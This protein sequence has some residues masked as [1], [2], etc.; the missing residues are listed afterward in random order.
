MFIWYC[1]FGIVFDI[2]FDMDYLIIDVF[3]QYLIDSSLMGCVTKFREVRQ[4]CSAV[5][6]ANRLF[7]RKKSAFMLK[8]AIINGDITCLDIGDLKGGKDDLFM[9][10]Y[11]LNLIYDMGTCYDFSYYLYRRK[12]CEYRQDKL[13]PFRLLRLRDYRSIKKMIDGSIMLSMALDHA[14]HSYSI[15]KMRAIADYY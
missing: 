4:E 7:Q 9:Y 2:V 3:A 10:K 15:N 5:I 6:D 1:L 8:K 14:E 13:S 11:M 12:C